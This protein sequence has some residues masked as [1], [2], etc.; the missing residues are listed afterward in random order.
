MRIERKR[1]KKPGFVSSIVAPAV[2]SLRCWGTVV[3]PSILSRSAGRVGAIVSITFSFSASAAVR[4]AACLT[5]LFAQA[6]LRP[7]VFA[8]PRSDAAASLMIFR[9]RSLPRFAP[10]PEIGV[11]EPMLVS[12]AIASTS[13][14]SE[15]QT[16]AD[17]ARAPPG[18]T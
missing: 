14:A 16:P 13:A 6:A 15:I 3:Q 17:A 5:A 2:C 7:W 1:V 9:R 12:G 4:L 18:E 8:R 11:E 10:V